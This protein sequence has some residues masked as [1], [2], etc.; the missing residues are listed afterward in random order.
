MTL[1]TNEFP[2]E[3]SGLPAA[4]AT[5]VAELSDGDRFRAAHRA[6]SKRIGDATV[7]MLAYNGSIPGPTLRVPEGSGA[8]RRR[9]E[10]GRHESDCP[11]ARA[12]AGEPLRRHARDAGSHPG[13]RALHRTRRFPRP[14]IYWYHPHIREDYNQEMGLYGNVVVA[15]SDPDYWLPVHRELTLTLDDVLIDGQV[16]AFSR[17]ETI[18]SAMGRFGNVLFV[19]GEPELPPDRPSGRGRAPVSDEHCQ[20]PRVQGRP[21]RSA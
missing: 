5:T 17:D 12:A 9:R 2:H 19:A 8:A 4:A 1:P 13:R 3:T 6:M 15:P 11:L 14:S 16:A 10:P 21:A 7:R 18:Y 20:H